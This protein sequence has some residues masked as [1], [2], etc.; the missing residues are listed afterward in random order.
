MTYF[1]IRSVATF[2][3]VGMSG[4]FA[5]RDSLTSVALVAG[6]WAVPFPYWLERLSIVVISTSV[7]MALSM[8]VRSELSTHM[9]Q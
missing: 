8:A 7:A 6:V 4:R 2:Q 5:A 1:V 3:M 9:C